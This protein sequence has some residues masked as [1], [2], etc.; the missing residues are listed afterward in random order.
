[1][2][3]PRPNIYKR[4]TASVPL[5]VT[6][7][8]HVV[9]I[10]IAGY[11][12][13]SEQIIGKKKIMEASAPTESVAQK[14]VEHRLQVA[15]KGGGSASS[16]PVSASRI[17][18]TASDS[19]QMPAMPDLPSV[20]ASSLAGMGF[21]A[22]MGA[23]GTGTGYNT[24]IGAGNGLG[25]GFMTMSFLGTTSQRV[26]KVVFIVDVGRDLLDIRKGGFEAFKIIR[27][28]IM[29]L[30]SRLP[31]SAEFSVVLYE[32]GSWNE[33]SVAAFSPTLLPATVG[34]KDDF[35]KWMTPVNSTP[36]R[37]G[38]ASA[39][40]RR[41]RWE[42]KP[43]PNAG[44]DPLLS[45]PTWSRA[46][47]FSLEMEPDT[48]FIISGARGDVRRDV[49]ETELAR[50]KRNYEKQVADYKR[51]GIDLEAVAAARNRALSKA[52]AELNEINTK[53]RAAGK[54]PFIITDTRRI[55]DG[56]FQAALKRAGHSITLDKT[57]WTDK[58]GQLIWW[59]GYSDHESAGFDELILHVSKLQRS[60]V[61]DRVAINY[62]L[63]VGP[64]EKPE[65]TMADLTKFTGRNGGKFQ[66]LTTKRL[67]EMS[68]RE[69]EK[70]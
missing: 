1:M 59:V 70:K 13:V 37:I 31:P 65:A 11:F 67:Q 68:A 42:K 4:I 53:L 40:G 21:G 6:V 2:S 46:L 10:A 23:V 15:R 58:Q 32:S 5:L 47:H 3:A 30:I 8:V 56:D 52:R 7:I 51:D 27:E 39:S 61:K 54:S 44:L 9:L 36:D 43:I 62:F 57:G 12:V 45:T 17:F 64:N 25:R 55:F 60:L 66:L 34:N 19:L 26:S 18:S 22:G 35:F 28:E 33:N 24:G 20:G 63:F 29:K 16:S 41:V 38:V 48:I 69:E 49:S 14:Q 50:R